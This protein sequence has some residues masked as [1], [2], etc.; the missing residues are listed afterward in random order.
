MDIHTSIP[1]VH[2]ERLSSD[3]GDSSVSVGG[4][5]G[6][7]IVDTGGR[8]WAGHMCFCPRVSSGVLVSQGVLAHPAPVPAFIPL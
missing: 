4:P 1:A 5:G 7:G 3:L 6:S 8:G 2:A